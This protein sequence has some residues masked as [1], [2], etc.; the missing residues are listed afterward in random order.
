M[1]PA[2]FD[3]SITRALHAVDHIPTP[4]EALSPS[5]DDHDVKEKELGSPPMTEQVKSASTSMNELEATEA[6]ELDPD[7]N[8]AVLRRAFLQAVVASLVLF[9]VLVLLVPLPLFG[10]NYI[11][12]KAGFTAYV[13]IAIAWVFYG[14]GAVVLYPIWESRSDLKRFGSAIYHDIAGKRVK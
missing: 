5:A 9:V 8:P 7:T 6:S 14:T 1:W 13:A 3:F 4:P 2:N 11:F 10:T 12:S